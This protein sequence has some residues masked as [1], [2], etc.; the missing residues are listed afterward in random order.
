[1]YHQSP[2][3]TLL[4][5]REAREGRRGVSGEDGDDFSRKG[6]CTNSYVENQSMLTH[7]LPLLLFLSS[8]LLLLF[9]LLDHDDPTSSPRG[10]HLPL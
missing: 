1:M 6:K 9:L 5:G 4:L 2:G 8:L 3:I 7:F 10:H